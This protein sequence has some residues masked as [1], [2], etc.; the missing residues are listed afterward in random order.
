MRSF[1]R[2]MHTWSPFSFAIS[3]YEGSTC[4]L[5]TNDPL[6]VCPLS[7]WNRSSYPFHYRMAFAFSSILCPPF[8][9]CPL[10]THLPFLKGGMSGLPCFVQVTWMIKSLLLHRQSYIRVPQ[11]KCEA[12]DCIPFR[13]EERRVGK[14]RRS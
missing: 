11:L 2:R 3:S 14:G 8:H 13:S 4:Y 1:C 9:R 6:E 7:R 12:T 5:V 10:R